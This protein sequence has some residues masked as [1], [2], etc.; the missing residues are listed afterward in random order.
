MTMPASD[1]AAVRVLLTFLVAFGALSTDLYLP[2]LPALVAVFDTTVA[3]MQLTLSVFMA[4]FA[5]AQLVY[6]PLS[7][8]FGR[9]W[10]L[11]G[12]SLLYTAASLSCTLADSAEV[13]IAARFFQ[14]LGACCG[15]VVARAVVRDVFD[16]E[17]TATVF[18][19]MGMAMGLAPVLAPVIGGLLL[20]T[21][22]W[23]SMF[24]VQ[25][26]LGVIAAGATAALL[27]ET[28]L[29]RDEGALRP[30]RLIVNYATLL[31]NRV[32]VGHALVASFTFTGL[33]AFI[34]A[35][36]F[37]LIDTLKLPPT[38]YGVCFASVA[39]GMMAGSFAAGRLSRRLGIDRMLRIGNACCLAAGTVGLGLAVAGVLNVASVLAPM[40]VFMIG[41][42]MTMPNAM[43]GAVGPFPRM[44]GLA[45]ALM[46]FLQMVIASGAGAVVGHFTQGDALPMMTAV[47]LA[48]VGARL[49]HGLAT[50]R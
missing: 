33:F 20:E 19:Y 21:A 49:A 34:S 26:L 46:G 48:A 47:F 28:N 5:V 9:R 22:G 13:L 24:L 32:F 10:T 14:A 7:D 37:V 31:G 2:A 23:R 44:A 42:G 6:G 27:G 40:I 15:P 50:P 18:A 1:S 16:R 3:R 25:A 17:R 11:I 4:G 38:V 12:G 41:Q 35:S 36:S 29:H 30:G 45:S 43:A 39:G 8:R